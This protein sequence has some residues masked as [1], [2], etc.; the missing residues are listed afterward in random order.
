MIKNDHLSQIMTKYGFIAKFWLMIYSRKGRWS[1]CVAD[2][3]LGVSCEYK[4]LYLH[5][6]SPENWIWIEFCG[7]ISRGMEQ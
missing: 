4:G 6:M 7:E 5:F 3:G 2:A 1:A